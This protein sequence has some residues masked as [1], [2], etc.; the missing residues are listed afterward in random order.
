MQ[1]HTAKMTVH[2][3]CILVGVALNDG[4]AGIISIQIDVAGV[5]L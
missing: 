5:G 3:T 4:V 2:R 1:S